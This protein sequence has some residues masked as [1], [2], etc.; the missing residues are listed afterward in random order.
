MLLRKVGGVWSSVMPGGWPWYAWNQ[1]PVSVQAGDFD[2]DGWPDVIAAKRQ[3]GEVSVVL[4]EA[5][6]I[7]GVPADVEVTPPDALWQ[8]VCGDFDDDGDL[9]AAAP[10]VWYVPKVHVL[11]N[12]GAGDLSPH[13]TVDTALSQIKPLVPVDFDADGHLDVLTSF[14]DVLLG[15]G[16]GSL[17]SSGA[18]PFGSSWVSVADMDGDGLLDGLRVGNGQMR[19]ALADGSGGFAGFLSVVTEWIPG[20]F[21]AGDLDGDLRPDLVASSYAA[22]MTVHLNLAESFAWTNLGGALAGGYGVPVLGGQGELLAGGPVSLRLDQVPAGAPV[23]LVA[24]LSLLAQPFKGGVL[25]PQPDF[26]LLGLAADADGFLEL[27][28]AWPDGLPASLAVNFQEWVT[29]PT[30]PHGLTASNGLTATAP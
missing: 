18:L 12:D 1:S 3:T 29:D 30:G 25:L 22:L 26:V 9:D 16:T 14:W 20:A 7:F 21:A 15:D 4:S 28:G 5:P 19:I 27:G 13:S 23:A 11:T 6:G 24:G 8:V 10:E 17:S 2:G